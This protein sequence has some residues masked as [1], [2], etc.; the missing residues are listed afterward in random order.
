MVEDGEWF[1][2][3]MRDFRL[4]CCDCGLVH[5]LQMRTSNGEV[6]IRIARNERATAAARRA[7]K[8]AVVIVDE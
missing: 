6:E 1:A 4:K 3:N 7:H 8:K 5:D 2:P